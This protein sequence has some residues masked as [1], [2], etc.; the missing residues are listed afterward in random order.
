MNENV[1]ACES[2]CFHNGTAG[3]SPRL[4]SQEK[5]I[6]ISGG[7]LLIILIDRNTLNNV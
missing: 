5:K 3:H 1:L 4:F 7:E 2:V 6:L